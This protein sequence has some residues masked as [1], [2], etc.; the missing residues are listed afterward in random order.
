MPVSVMPARSATPLVRL[1]LV[2]RSDDEKD[3]TDALASLTGALFDHA[4]VEHGLVQGDGKH[5]VRLEPNGVVEPRLV[6][7]ADD[8]DRAHADPV[9]REPDANVVLGQLL[10][11]EERL[12]RG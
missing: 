2:T 5:L 1:D 4:V 3:A 6:V 12:E 8:V 9:A 7:D 11:V 10:L